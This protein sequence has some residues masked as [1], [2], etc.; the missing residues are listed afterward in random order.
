MNITT[1]PKPTPTP[2]PSIYSPGKTA[3]KAAPPFIIIVLV[4]AAK[5]ALQAAG[6]IVDDTTLFSAALAGYGALT[7][8]INWIK[9]RKK[10]A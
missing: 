9:N 6:I 10:T 5:A 7:G 2:A 1:T 8:F 3:W 4:N